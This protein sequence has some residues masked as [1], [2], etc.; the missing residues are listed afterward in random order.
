MEV[1]C[2]VVMGPYKKELHVAEIRCKESIPPQLSVTRQ[3]QWYYHS[4][5]FKR[6]PLIETLNVQPTLQ[7]LPGCS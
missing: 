4:F 7:V 5:S 3:F 6:I 1:S 2:P